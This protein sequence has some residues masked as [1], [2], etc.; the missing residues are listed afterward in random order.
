M[1]CCLFPV[2][3]T[4]PVSWFCFIPPS[5]F[6]PLS[7]SIGCVLSCLHDEVTLVWVEC[8]LWVL[9]LD[10]N[11]GLVCWSCLYSFGMGS[12][13]GVKC[14]LRT[15]LIT[16]EGLPFAIGS[17]SFTLGSHVRCFCLRLVF[18]W[19]DI[20]VCF[21]APLLFSVWLL[22]FCDLPSLGIFSLLRIIGPLATVSSSCFPSLF[23]LAE[24]SVSLFLLCS[25]LQ[26]RVVLRSLCGLPC[27]LWNYS[28]MGSNPGGFFFYCLGFQLLVFGGSRWSPSCFLFEPVAFLSSSRGLLRC[29]GTLCALCFAPFWRLWWLCLSSVCGALS[30]IPVFWLSRSSCLCLS[31]FLFS[32]FCCL[33]YLFGSFFLFCALASG[34]PGVSPVTA[35]SS[36]G[37]P[38][39]LSSAVAAASSPSFGFSPLANVLWGCSPLGEVPLGPVVPARLV[40]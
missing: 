15:L 34:P 1:L 35:L 3:L 37:R 8:R 38:A 4:P 28:L 19:L 9:P 5:S 27:S 16:I 24:S 33:I 31:L 25:S 30:S 6:R 29:R 11:E 13:F 36:V 17:C 2:S 22:L 21:C 20:I 10:R 26:C 39:S 14:V 12:P 32:F 7:V 18:S 23:L 40:I